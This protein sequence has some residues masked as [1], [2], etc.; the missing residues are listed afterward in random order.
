MSEASSAWS[1]ELESSCFELTPGNLEQDTVIANDQVRN[2]PKCPLNS[3]VSLEAEHNLEYTPKNSD[4]S[5]SID[6]ASPVIDEDPSCSQS[7]IHGSP[8]IGEEFILSRVY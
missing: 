7:H 1:P 8:S 5:R 4:S 6:N 2:S 3:A